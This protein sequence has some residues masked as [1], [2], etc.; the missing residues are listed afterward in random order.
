M[1]NLEEFIEEKLGRQEVLELMLKGMEAKLKEDAELSAEEKAKIKKIVS[2]N[3]EVF[4][5]QSK[6]NAKV[7][8]VMDFL[9]NI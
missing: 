1:D 4:D 2:L 6:L 3:Q 8:E 5:L 7:K 9:K